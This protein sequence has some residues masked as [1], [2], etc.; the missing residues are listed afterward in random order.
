MPSVRSFKVLVLLLVLLV[1]I[2]TQVFAQSS[3]SDD[4]IYVLGAVKSPGDFEFKSGMT[5]KD[6]LDMAGGLA[7][8][9]DKE[10]LVLLREDGTRLNLEVDS[11]MQGKDKTA[12][13][14]GDTIV[15]KP[16][17]TNETPAPTKPSEPAAP[18]TPEPS[19]SQ[20]SIKVEGLVKAPGSF[21]LKPGMSAKDALELAGGAKEDAATSAAYLTRAGNVIAVDFKDSASGGLLQN[22]DVLTIPG[23]SA[24]ITGEVRKPGTYTLA[25]GKTDNLDGLINQAGGVTSSSDMKNVRISSINGSER[26]V[27]N[28]DGST[29]A[30][31]L[32]I[33]IQP[34]DA[35]FVPVI[36][37]KP[38][39]RTSLNEVYQFTIILAT[40]VSIFHH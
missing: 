33:P 21:A 28:V 10:G 40:L 4:R 1:C 30:E 14:A 3:S 39:H 38:K 35:V 13:M 9:A 25:A 26:P 15:V 6:A 37:S 18:T 16:T 2:S 17:A 32:K 19:A 5:V 24:S 27:R 31:R 23:F 7:S 22:G 8:N 34:G 11:V 20:G 12:L 29:K 36:T